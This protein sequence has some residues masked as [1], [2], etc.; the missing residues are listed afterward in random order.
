MGGLGAALLGHLADA[1]GIQFVYRL[2]AYLPALG[3]LAAFL[4]KIHTPHRK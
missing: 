4:P 3:V 2:C 1:Q